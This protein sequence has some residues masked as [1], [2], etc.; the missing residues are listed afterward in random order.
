[1][2]ATFPITDSA[3]HPIGPG[4]ISCWTKQERFWKREGDHSSPPGRSLGFWLLDLLGL[5][6]GYTDGDELALVLD[7]SIDFLLY[8]GAGERPVRILKGFGCVVPT[9]IWHRWLPFARAP[10]CS[11]RRCRRELSIAPRQV[12]ATPG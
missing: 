7:G 10:S 9:G 3:L 5:P 12:P 2:T 1:M 4:P 11:L 8:Y 6:G